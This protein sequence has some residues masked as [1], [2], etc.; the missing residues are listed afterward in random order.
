MAKTCADAAAEDQ[1]RWLARDG[2]VAALTA[3]RLDIVLP[4]DRA[5]EADARQ[6]HRP[7]V[8]LRAVHVVGHPLV[9]GHV[10]ELR[11]RLV[12]DAGPRSGAVEA[13]DG[14]AVVALD[15]PIGVARVDPQGVVVAVRRGNGFEGLAAV[16]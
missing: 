5:F 6:T 8:L 16:N 14:A 3:A 7:I 12:Q 1:V 13:D 11:R 10:I 15:H 9:G 2:Q 4:G